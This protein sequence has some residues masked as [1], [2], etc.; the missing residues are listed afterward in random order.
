[1]RSCPLVAVS[2]RQNVRGSSTDVMARNCWTGST[3]DGHCF[4]R[5]QEAMYAAPPFQRTHTKSRD[6]VPRTMVAVSVSTICR[7][8]W[9]KKT[10]PVR[11]ALVQFDKLI[12]WR[13]SVL[14][15]VA[16]PE[17]CLDSQTSAWRVLEHRRSAEGLV[18]HSVPRC[19]ESHS[20]VL[21]RVRLLRCGGW[22]L[23]QSGL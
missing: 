21:D 9:R 14:S 12:N 16:F 19:F 18:I 3:P 13:S 4:E 23:S 11:V 7:A 17:R 10:G 5:R 20:A 6:R 8:V 22:T 1:M 2:G 15:P